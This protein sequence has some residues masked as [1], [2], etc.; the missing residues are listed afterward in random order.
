M[1]SENSSGLSRRTIAK[2]AA[3]AAPAVVVAAAAPKVSASPP[4]PPPP[5]V[6]TFGDACGNTG[7]TQ[8]GCGGTKTLQVPLTLT[9]N[10]GVGVVF[11]IT[12]MYT[13][14]CDTTPTGPG[15]GVYSGI[16]GIWST[17]S[18]AVADQNDCT[19]VVAA[20]SAG[21]VTGGS[22]LVPHGTT[23]QTYW[24]ESAV[25]DDSSKFST[26]IEWRM[27]SAATCAQLFT[28]SAQTTSAI[29]PQ[30]CDG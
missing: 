27:L 14:N 1:T 5:P 16:R 9:N 30:N 6:I 24:I 15:T 3:W 28:G 22:V 10:T 25:T 19:A 2:G 18:H 4:P 12:A 11:Q 7:A 23:G 20:C 26:T 17:P 8:K 13:C 21:G 29:S